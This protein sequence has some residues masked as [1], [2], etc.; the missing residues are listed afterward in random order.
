MSALPQ[1]PYYMTVKRY[2]AYDRD[3]DIKNEYADQKIFAMAGAKRRHNL[4]CTNIVRKYGNRISDNG[5][6]I[7]QSDMRVQAA[8]AKSYRYPDVVMVCGEAQ[9]ADSGQDTLVNPTVLIEVLSKSTAEVDRITKAWEYRQIPSLQDYL[10][11]ASDKATVEWYHR[12]DNGSWLISM[13][14][15]LDQHI[16]LESVKCSLLL[17]DM[18]EKIDFSEDDD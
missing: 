6:E 17:G 13:I 16:R 4:V 10:V 7:Y 18:Y 8:N 15:G 14:E 5:C 2:L 9:F 12:Q 11:V 1:Q 3:S